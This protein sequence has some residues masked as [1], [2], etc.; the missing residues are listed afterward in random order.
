MRRQMRMMKT[1]PFAQPEM[2][3]YNNLTSLNIRLAPALALLLHM[4]EAVGL[5]AYVRII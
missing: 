5:S 1:E 4:F 3:A 2:P